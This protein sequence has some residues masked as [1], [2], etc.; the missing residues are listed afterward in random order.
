MLLRVFNQTRYLRAQRK[1]R[2]AKG[3]PSLMEFVPS[4]ASFSASTH[5]RVDSFGSTT[6]REINEEPSRRHIKHSSKTRQKPKPK[7]KQTHL[8]QDDVSQHARVHT[9]RQG[10]RPSQR[11]ACNSRSLR[12]GLAQQFSPSVSHS[13]RV[14][15][16]AAIAVPLNAEG[17]TKP[18]TAPMSTTRRK[19]NSFIF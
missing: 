3:M 16:G 10:A 18:D 13:P 14:A 8:L 17:A 6:T 11:C 2:E 1:T 9:K 15:R 19:A 7:P 5:E 12:Q 4:K